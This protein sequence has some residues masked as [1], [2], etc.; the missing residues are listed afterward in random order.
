VNTARLHAG[1]RRGLIL[2]RCMAQGKR[3]V[4]EAWGWLSIS[5]IS[6]PTTIANTR[7][8]RISLQD[9]H[10][11]ELKAERRDVHIAQGS[12][13]QLLGDSAEHRFRCSCRCALA[14]DGRSCGNRQTWLVTLLDG[15]CT[16]WG[17]IRAR[18]NL[19]VVNEGLYGNDQ[20]KRTDESFNAQHH[21]LSTCVTSSDREVVMLRPDRGT[22]CITCRT[23]TRSWLYSTILTGVLQFLR[24]TSPHPSQVAWEMQPAC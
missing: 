10:D 16:R 23:F 4:Q 13:R 7:T 19:Q 1:S 8:Y 18:V 9:H 6:I 22:A 14:S 20:R 12:A 24:T 3:L 2:W 11:E 21:C 17:Y 15:V 5:A